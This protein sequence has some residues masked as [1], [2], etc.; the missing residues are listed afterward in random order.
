MSNMDFDDFKTVVISTVIITNITLNVLVVA[1]VAR[2]PQLREDRTALFMFSIAMSDLANGCTSMSL[3]AAL[4]SRATPNVRNMTEYLPGV[5]AFFS[6][7][8]S[9]NSMHSLCWMTIYKMVAITNPFRCE[10]LLTRSRCY[11]LI[12]GIWFTGAVIGV[13][14]IPTS[15]AWNMNACGFYIDV[16]KGI[17]SVLIIDVLIGIVWPTVAIFYSTTRIFITIIRTHRQISA[18]LNSIGGGIGEAAP[19]LS[20][21]S[22]RSGRNV[23]LICFTF[24]LLTA[25]F[26]LYFT[27]IAFG[28]DSRI[29]YAFKFISVWLFFFNSSSNSLIYILVFRSVRGRTWQMLKDGYNH[30][31]SR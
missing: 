1:V 30:C 31:I 16:P 8:F 27:L 23:L 28:F 6:A 7:W 22:I 3:S 20:V 19:S 29:P 12:C 4:C 17:V 9:F 11:L 26:A 25:P 10:Q 2:Y 14:L 5:H 13:S 15:T 21:N 24:V 18:Q